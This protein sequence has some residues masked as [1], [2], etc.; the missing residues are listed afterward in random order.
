MS[1]ESNYNPNSKVVHDSWR[2]NFDALNEIVSIWWKKSSELNSAAE[3]LYSQFKDAIDKLWVEGIHIEDIRREYGSIWM[4][5]CGYSIECL[6]KGLYFLVN[7]TDNIKQGKIVVDWRG[8]GHELL[9]LL[10]LYNHATSPDKKI[11]LKDNELDYIKRLSEFTIWAGKYPIPKRYQNLIPQESHG[12]YAPLTM[13]AVEG[14]KD[15]YDR[16]YSQLF[17][18]IISLSE[19]KLKKK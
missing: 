1:N 9:K 15:L 10:E 17:E 5:L 13:I 18:L 6:F 4:M 14:D 7:P 8:S 3:L 16:I 19:D 12:G 2:N 11:E